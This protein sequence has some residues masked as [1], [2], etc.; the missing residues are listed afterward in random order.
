MSE[1]LGGRKKSFKTGRQSRHSSPELNLG[2]MS[3]M[4]QAYQ[5]FLTQTK[6]S[7]Q[8]SFHRRKTCL[9]DMARRT[10]KAFVS[11]V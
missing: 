4:L 11:R 9:T 6:C 7:W 8:Q 3:E 2:V 10:D 1:F 5:V